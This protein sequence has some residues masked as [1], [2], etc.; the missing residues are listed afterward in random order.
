[1]ISLLERFYRAL[2]SQ[3]VTFWYVVAFVLYY[4]TFTI[5][6]E[7]AFGRFINLISTNPLAIVLYSVFLVNITLLMGRKVWTSLRAG[8]CSALFRIP[9]Y[10]GVAL[11]LVSSFLSLTTRE[12]RWQLLGRGDPLQVPW[13]RGVFR[14]DGIESALRQSML[15]TEDSLIFDY[16][17]VVILSDSAGNRY[18]VGAF[19][20]EKVGRSYMH[21]LNFGIGPGVELSRDGEIISRGYFA[22]RLVPFGGTDSFEIKPMPYKFFLTVIPNDLIRKAGEEVRLYN[23]ERPRYRVEILKGD[24]KVFSGETEDSVRFDGMKLRFLKPEN[25]VLLEMVYNPF[26]LPYVAGLT[27]LLAGLFLYPFSMLGRSGKQ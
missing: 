14:V 6:S 13:E 16:E 5:W 17:P 7:E 27:V 26:Y 9:L 3:A 22:L 8:R 11:F 15:R 21:V 10:L 24:R 20:P 4:L 12:V 18:R 2:S 19:P 23:I 1:M 25:W